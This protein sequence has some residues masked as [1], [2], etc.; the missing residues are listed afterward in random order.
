ML[1]PQY[2]KCPK[3]QDHLKHF[4][5]FIRNRHSIGLLLV[6]QQLLDMHLASNAIVLKVYQDI[7]I[8]YEHIITFIENK[9]TSLFPIYLYRP[10]ADYPERH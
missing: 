10:T 1:L 3:N 6:H 2:L 4:R 8:Y 5:K 7:L 9:V